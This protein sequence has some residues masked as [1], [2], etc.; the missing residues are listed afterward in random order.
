[1]PEP[2]HSEQSEH[3]IIKLALAAIAHEPRAWS[4]RGLADAVAKAGGWDRTLV[5]AHL[6][7]FGSDGVAEHYGARR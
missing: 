1:M 6:L 5:H 7:R 4:I 3:H 2:L